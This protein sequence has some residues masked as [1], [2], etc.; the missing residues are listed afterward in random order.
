MSFSSDVKKELG[1][2]ECEPCCLKSELYSII[3]YK[4]E[5]KISSGGLGFTLQ[6]TLNVVARRIVYLL[7][8]IYQRD[9][10]IE[11]VKMNKLDY[12]PRYVI[13]LNEDGTDILKDLKILNP[14]YTINE[15][16]NYDIFKRSCCKGALVRGLFLV[17]GSIND[18]ASSNYHLEIILDSEE[19]Y[20]IINGILEEVG[21]SSKLTKRRKGYV[22]YIKKSEMI[23]D[24]L[25]FVGANNSLF[26]FENQRIMRDYN[27]SVNRIINCD[28]ANEEKVMK[29]SKEQL[30]NIDFLTKSRGIVNLPERILNAIVL[31]TTYPDY[32]LSELSDESLELVG[33]YISKS[34][35]SHCYKDIER[36]CNEIK[37]QIK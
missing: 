13:S 2:V 29:S 28:I 26:Y 7:K 17:Q 20:E 33:K 22:L 35:L 16:I 4:S 9:L 30:A 19:D 32:S 36:M 15:Q 5:L 27:N 11:L 37:G 31:R 3:R 6:T 8:T 34:G 23:G 10:D 18:P 14:D 1:N 24:F 25:K 12:K 21:I